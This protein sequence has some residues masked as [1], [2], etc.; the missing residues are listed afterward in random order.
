MKSLPSCKKVLHDFQF[1]IVLLL[2]S[3]CFA[4]YAQ[5]QTYNMSNGTSTTCSGTFYDS[6][7]P[8]GAYNNNEN[9]TKSFCSCN[10]G[11]ITVSFT[12]FN[13]EN[14]YDFLYIYNGPNTTSP[15]VGV[16]TGSTSPGTVTSSGTCLTFNFTSDGSVTPAGWS[17]NI[18]CT[19]AGPPVPTITASGPTTFC[20]G[21]SVTLT[22]SSGTSYSWST[23]ATTSSINV[24][25]SGTYS[26]TVTTAGCSRTSAP[27]TVTVNPSPT[28]T[29]TPGSVSICSGNS[30]TLTA[31]GGSTYSWAPPGGLSATTGA[32]VTANPT[33]TTTYTVTGTNAGGCTN[34][35]SVTVTVNAAP[36]I[37]IITASGNTAICQGDSVQLTSSSATGYLWS[38]NQTT[39]SI[40]VGSAGTYSVTITDAGGCSATS[41]PVTVT[42]SPAPA[43]PV[44]TP[45]GS[46]TFCQGGSVQ[47]TSS[48]AASYWW[49]DNST[50]QAIIV[51]AQ[52]NYDVTITNADGCSAVSA[53]VMVTV[54]PSPVPNLGPDTIICIDASLF[55]V[56]GGFT[57]YLWQDNS[58]SPTYTAI[59]SSLGVD[60]HLI[61]VNVTDG[62]GCT[63][64][65]T[66]VLV[67]S[68]C[69]GMDEISA[70]QVNISPNPTTGVLHI[71]VNNIE[72][73]NL[74]L[75]VRNVTGQLV[76][77]KKITKV[78]GNYSGEA[79][80][81]G[82][83]K[84]L[85]FLEIS[86]GI[87]SSTHKII[88][89]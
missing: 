17:A 28:V 9:Y 66:M 49:S 59:G 76:F 52:G 56:A 68:S 35:A 44:I 89:Q 42:V 2:T 12:S 60:T 15:L 82:L 71:T 62:N 55:L 30:A 6:G 23:G 47:L 29:V 65:D 85:Y 80:I 86:D 73:N 67:V 31:T 4:T 22:S 24:T 83:A 72:T 70:L 27:T 14:I 74:H 3:M 5:A 87:N 37:P 81:S 84:G 34:S 39:Q 21:G 11:T 36:P 88:L 77:E 40:L 26:V 25:T 38:N 75:T 54:N 1:H 64:S 69:V 51:T 63:G 79:D 33:I 18:S 45:G 57:N 61:H 8:T 58:T 48:S 20:S 78:S 32:S 7:G 19:P 43:T 10:G 46:T 13:V 53:P 50:T 16:Y 41:A